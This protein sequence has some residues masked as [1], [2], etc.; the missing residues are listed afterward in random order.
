MGRCYT[1]AMRRL[2]EALSLVLIGL[3]PFH[4]LFVTVGTRVLTGPGHAPM[5]ALALWKEGLLGVLLALAA[6]E[7]II[8]RGRAD[9]KKIDELDALILALGA[10]AVLV[11][12]F[13]HGDPKLFA[14]GFKYDLLAPLAFVVLRRA[15]WSPAFLR[16]AGKVLA[17]AAA[18]LAAY[19]LLA[20]LA[21]D[22]FFSALGYSDL[23]SLYVP[24]GPLAAYQQI[25]STGLR[26]MQSAMSGPNQLGLWMLLPWSVAA[27]MLVNALR[28]RAGN[29]AT[30]LALALMMASGLCV[31]LSYSRSAWIGA[32]AIGLTAV[33]FTV[34]GKVRVW[35]LA[36]AAG[37]ATLVILALSLLAPAVFLRFASSRDHIT[38][39]IQ[40]IQRIVRS[41]LGEGLGAAGPA[42]NRVSDA[43]VFLD[44]GADASW[45]ADR[46]SLCVL[47]G[48]QQVQPTDRACVCPFL[49]ENWYL[50]IGVE[51][52]VLGFAVFLALTILLIVRLGRAGP[53]VTGL[54]LAVLGIAVGALF[55]HAWE[56]AAVAFTL[57]LLSAAALSGGSGSGTPR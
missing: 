6:A 22:A 16:L 21:P 43:C 12:A 45:A 52:G 29:R 13:T 7:I 33:A 31:L 18:V 32:F 50:Q 24:G 17:G 53:G 34:P 8:G 23:H 20:L 40:A 10:L 57:W 37:F 14:L 35:L 27:A 47:V 49:P 42:S 55:L 38:R 4:A 39:P 48:D 3:L 2:R 15:Q 1:F 44:A 5:A 36:S 51:L 9:W 56:D 28:S 41:P 30:L 54:R 19:G 25:G 11:T 26:R 46:P